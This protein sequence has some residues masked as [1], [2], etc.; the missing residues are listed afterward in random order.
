MFY[1]GSITEWAK[2]IG[3][4]GWAASAVVIMLLVSAGFAIWSWASVKK[5]GLD[6][7][8]SK[9]LAGKVNVLAPIHE[10]ERVNLADFYSPFCHAIANVRFTDCEILGPATVYFAGGTFNGV[11]FTECDIVIIRADRPIFGATRFSQPVFL[12]GRVVRLTMLM[13]IEEYQL[14]PQGVRENVPVISDGRIG[15][16]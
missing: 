5:G 12:R 2:W 11:S 3:P 1:L 16:L 9:I 7:A 4:L 14:L 8:K 15:D 6:L 13:T 10:H